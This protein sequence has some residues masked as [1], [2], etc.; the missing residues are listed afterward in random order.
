[1]Q[2]PIKTLVTEMISAFD[3]WHDIKLDIL[4]PAIK[5]L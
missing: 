5:I 1:M 4:A 2:S 3:F